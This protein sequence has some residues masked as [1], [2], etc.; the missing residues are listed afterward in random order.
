MDRHL[1]MQFAKQLRKHLSHICFVFAVV[2]AVAITGIAGPAAA[3]DN[4]GTLRLINPEIFLKGIRI[5]HIVATLDGADFGGCWAD[6]RQPNNVCIRPQPISA[7]P[8]VLEILLD[9]LTSTY[10]T[11]VHKFNAAMSAKCPFCK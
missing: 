9:P 10:F 8:H 6:R 1:E 5:K 4:G 3:E 11:W 2:A 7:G